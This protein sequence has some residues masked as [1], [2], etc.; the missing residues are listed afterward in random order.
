[1]CTW[2]KS[3]YCAR[4]DTSS[5]SNIQDT[6]KLVDEMSVGSLSEPSAKQKHFVR[7]LYYVNSVPRICLFWKESN[8]LY[9]IVQCIV[10]WSFINIISAYIQQSLEIAKLVVRRQCAFLTKRDIRTVTSLQTKNGDIWCKKKHTLQ[11]EKYEISKYGIIL[12]RTAACLALK[13]EFRQNRLNFC[14]TT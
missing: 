10:R 9:V 6:E 11:H 12:I 14:K 1:M 13:M 2:P 8:F 4:R 7:N 5:G 3:V